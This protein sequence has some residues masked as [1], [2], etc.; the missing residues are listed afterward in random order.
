MEQGEKLMPNQYTRFLVPADSYEI[1]GDK[2]L[3]GQGICH[4]KGNNN[5][6]WS[7]NLR[8][9]LLSVCNTHT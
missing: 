9:Q 5:K 1:G 8:F 7:R 3:W 2:R 4:K 6:S